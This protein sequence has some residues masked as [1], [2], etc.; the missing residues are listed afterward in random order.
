MRTSD[1][2][3]RLREAEDD[4]IGDVTDLELIHDRTELFAASTD[5]TSP[6]RLD[7]CPY[8]GLAA[9][10][11][12]DADYY[13]GRERLVAE[14]IARLVG[15]SFLGLVG[16]SGSGKSSA[17]RAGLTPALAGGVLPGSEQWTV[18]V[19]RPGEHPLGELQ[20]VARREPRYEAGRTSGR[21]PTRA[22]R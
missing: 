13:F 19:M 15:G 10:E 17:L 21:R 7:V 9:F 1:G 20:R 11:P 8:K 2:R 16:A 14:L 4:L 3:R 18:A 12:A 5:A 6:R 22:R